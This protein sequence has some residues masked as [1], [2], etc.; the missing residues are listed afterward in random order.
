MITKNKKEEIINLFIAGK[1]LKQIE[2]EVHSTFR[3]IVKV[4]TE[5]KLYKRTQTSEKIDGHEWEI[6]RLYCDE[7]KSVTYIHKYLNISE[8]QIYNFLK[9]E[10]LI[11]SVG[12]NFKYTCDHDFF[13][14]ID[15]EEKAYWLGVIYADGNV[16]KRNNSYFL[17]ISS[18]DKDWLSLFFKSIASNHI[19]YRE[20]HKKFNKYIYKVNITSN[21]LCEDLINLG[22]VPN[23]SKVITMPLI[24]DNLIR[25]F[26]RGYF[27]GDGTVSYDKYLSY[28]DRCTLRS[29]ICSGSKIF[30]EQILQYIPSKHK[31]I[32]KRKNGNLYWFSLS[33]KDS[34]QFYNYMYHEATIYLPR[35][36]YIFEKYF[37][38]KQKRSETIIDNP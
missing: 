2:K 29:G 10:N 4:L 5:C 1:N 35:K 23:K 7:L 15:T 33:V 37:L 6:K 38:N 27:D 36:K 11:R 17:R 12:K 14:N 9:K 26:I 3:S 32:Q 28:S 21:K 13:F 31:T 30:I 8:H 20:Y 19:L 16:S 18:I 25:H 22:C 34:V 24:P